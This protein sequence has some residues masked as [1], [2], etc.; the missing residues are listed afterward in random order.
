MQNLLVR[1]YFYLWLAEFWTVLIAFLCLTSFKKLPSIGVKSADK[2]VH[3]TFYFVFTILWFLYFNNKK[4]NSNDSSKALVTKVFFV[5][6]LYGIGIEIAQSLF[7]TTRKGDVLDVIANTS[8][9]LIA[10]FLV[11][12]WSRFYKKKDNQIK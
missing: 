4:L 2:Y 9:G 1:K 10:V 6:V 7:T 3:F 12:V 11:V 8:G 5:A